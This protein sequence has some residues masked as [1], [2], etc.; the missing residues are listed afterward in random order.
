MPDRILQIA[1]SLKSELENP[2]IWKSNV[3]FFLCGGA[4]KDKANFRSEIRKTI[5]EKKYK[6]DYSVHF[7]ED[8]FFDL[9]LGHQQHDLLSLE[10]MLADNVHCVIILLDSPGTIAELGAFSNHDIL[11]TKLVLVVD[12]KYRKSKSFI[13]LGPV[14]FIKKSGSKIIYDSFEKNNWPLI[15]EKILESSREIHE[16]QTVK[17]NL[18][19]PIWCYYFYL[20][21]IYIFDPIEKDKLY[22]LVKSLASTPEEKK[23]LQVT[24]SSSLSVLIKDQKIRSNL[25]LLSTN[26]NSE[27]DVFKLFRTKE[28]KKKIDDL[29]TDF[30]LEA[31]EQTLR[32]NGWR[33]WKAVAA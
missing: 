13:N 6:Y 28:R 32:G 4:S 19:N 24:L 33:K 29:F 12:E 31:L 14:R 16:R 26:K 27:L 7:P 25:N 9:I 2:E 22:E 5:L 11:K 10:N 21:L 20:S 30:R 1:Q 18:S 23:W 17:R 3:S 15:V 8:M